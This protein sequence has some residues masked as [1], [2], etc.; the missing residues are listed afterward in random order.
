MKN[1]NTIVFLIVTGVILTFL[2]LYKD[3]IIGLKEMS[4]NTTIPPYNMP[5]NLQI[6]TA[7]GSG[8]ISR[9]DQRAFENSINSVINNMNNRMNNINTRMANIEGIT[10]TKTYVDAQL[11]TKANNSYN[12]DFTVAG[13]IE[14][15]INKLNNTRTNYVKKG[16]NYRIYAST[17][18]D[19]MLYMPTDDWKRV[20]GYGNASSNE[21]GFIFQI[22]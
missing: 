10:A 22:V 5:G 17:G 2:Y 21:P 4:V 12:S 16:T 19:T 13:I 20:K 6:V 11:A 1:T 7:D 3:E 14:D 18:R 8:N 15:T 9:M